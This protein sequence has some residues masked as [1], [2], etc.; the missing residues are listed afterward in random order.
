VGALSDFTSSGGEA[1]KHLLMTHFPGYQPI[2]EHHSPRQVLQEPAQEDWDLASE[3]FNEDKV[4][5]ALMGL[6]PLR[7]QE[8]MEYFRACCNMGLKLS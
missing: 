1:A 6:V 8:R 7:Q 5:W 2:E 4:R 3:V